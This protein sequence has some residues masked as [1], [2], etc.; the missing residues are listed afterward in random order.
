MPQILGSS[1]NKHVP[2]LGSTVRDV[3][4]VSKCLRLCWVTLLGTL[5]RAALPL[6]LHTDLYQTHIL[7]PQHSAPLWFPLP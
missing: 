6:P 5:M 2:T 7:S 1:M 4:G 3:L